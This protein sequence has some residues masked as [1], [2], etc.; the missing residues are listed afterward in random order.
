VHVL[1]LASEALV[2][3]CEPLQQRQF[4]LRFELH[5]CGATQQVSCVLWRCETNAATNQFPC[6]RNARCPS[7]AQ[8]SGA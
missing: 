3:V 4:L 6:P 5:A 7:P 2:L 1:K 8:E